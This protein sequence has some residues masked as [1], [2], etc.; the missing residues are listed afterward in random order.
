MFSCIDVKRLALVSKMF[1]K[2]VKPI[3]E[4]YHLLSLSYVKSP[5]S[6]SPSSP[7]PDYTLLFSSSTFPSFPLH[8]FSKFIITVRKCCL[9]W[10]SLEMKRSVNLVFGR[11][12]TYVFHIT[13]L[14]TFFFFFFF[15][16]YLIVF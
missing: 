16:I 6:P 4:K 1:Y 5:L 10:L 11:I 14:F 8:C 15:V 2:L 3:V 12:F 9:Q 7:T 13:F